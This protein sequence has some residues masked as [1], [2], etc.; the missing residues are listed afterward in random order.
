MNKDQI[1]TQLKI[2]I[3]LLYSSRTDG[4]GN[5]KLTH[6]Q[7]NFITNEAINL[8]TKIHSQADQSLNQIIPKNSTFINPPDEP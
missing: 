6:S 1:K 4:Y 8:L 7:R 2:A 3:N 5:G